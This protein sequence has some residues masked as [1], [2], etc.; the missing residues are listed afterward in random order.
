MAG[1][2][3]SSLKRRRRWGNGNCGVE[4]RDRR[5]GCVRPCSAPRDP[6]RQ[7]F[8][9]LVLWRVGLS[10]EDGKNIQTAVVS[11]EAKHVRALSPDLSRVRRPPT[12]KDYTTRR[13]R[14]VFGTVEVR[15]PR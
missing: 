8:G 4:T 12:V 6:H 11:H 7:E 13:I 2:S 14:T 1:P 15:N 3:P 9:T 5:S 10:V